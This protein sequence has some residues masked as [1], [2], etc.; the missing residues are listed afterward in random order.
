[1]IS[2]SFPSF[3]FFAANIAK[4][5]VHFTVAQV[6]RLSCSYIENRWL[7]FSLFI[8]VWNTTFLQR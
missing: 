4:Y 3:A 1:M 2:T 6:G 5:S 7:P 8:F